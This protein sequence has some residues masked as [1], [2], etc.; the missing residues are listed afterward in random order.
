MDF[1]RCNLSMDDLVD[2]EK[3][4][5][6]DLSFLFDERA[7]RMFLP[8]GEFITLSGIFQKNSHEKTE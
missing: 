2:R 5:P 6:L 1:I 7:Q 3:T 8:I 4:F